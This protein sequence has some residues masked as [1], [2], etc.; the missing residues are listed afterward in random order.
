MFNILSASSMTRYRSDRRLNPLVFSRWSTSRPGVAEM[1][2]KSFSLRMRQHMEWNDGGLPI[3]ICGFLASTRACVIMSM[4]P[5][6][7][8]E[9]RIAL[10]N[11]VFLG[12]VSIKGQVNWATAKEHSWV[13]I[14]L[15]LGPAYLFFFTCTASAKNLAFTVHKSVQYRYIIACR[16]YI[17][18]NYISIKVLTTLDTNTGSQG[19][20][21]LWDLKCQ[22]SMVTGTQVNKYS[23]RSNQQTKIHFT[24]SV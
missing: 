5:T 22:L 8:A 11:S 19:L 21:L 12:R 10:P 23:T 24:W 16:K 18:K 7:T 14:A 9:K 1:E 20:H 15:F 4:P 17:I 6:T 2:Q 13:L 3:T